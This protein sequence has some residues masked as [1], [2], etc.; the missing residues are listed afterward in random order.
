MTPAVP[1]MDQRYQ[2]LAVL[3]VLLTVSL[4]I[5]GWLAVGSLLAGM[6]IVV[7]HEALGDRQRR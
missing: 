7:A 4:L 6:G 1:T 5:G 2:F 3:L